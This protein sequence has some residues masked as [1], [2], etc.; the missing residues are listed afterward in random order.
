M[1][2]AHASTNLHRLSVNAR[3]GLN[4]SAKFQSAA[5]GPRTAIGAATSG[6]NHEYDDGFVRVDRTGNTGGTTWFWGYSEPAQVTGNSIAFHSLSAT[7]DGSS[8][9]VDSDPQYGLELVY[10]R[11]LGRL[12]ARLRWGVE[13]GLGW[14]PLSIQDRGD[15]R[16]GVEEITDTYAFQPGTTPPAAPYAG[17]FNGP[18]FLLFDTPTRSAAPVAGATLGGSREFEA[19]LFALRLGPGLEWEVG[20]HGL[21]GVS[22]G[23]A[24]GGLQGDYTWTQQLPG[25]GGSGGSGSDS[26]FLVGGYVGATFTWAF[27]EQW[28]AQVGA[29]FMT[30]GDYSHTYEGARVELDLSRMLWISAGLGYS[31]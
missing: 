7:A 20:R 24:I 27:D 26:D 29:Q 19:D 8:G 22:G 16:G 15:L 11:Q 28:S 6:A 23:L 4:I 21:L 5:T 10:Q 3:F 14:A 31:F 1:P 13:A 9:E 30:L 12:G 18:G 17:T 2:L 25:G